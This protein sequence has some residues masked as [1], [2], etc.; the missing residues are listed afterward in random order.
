MNHQ[1][2]CLIYAPYLVCIKTRR[3]RPVTWREFLELCLKGHWMISLTGILKKEKLFMTILVSMG[4][5]WNQ[6]HFAMVPSPTTSMKIFGEG[7]NLHYDSLSCI[8]EA[9]H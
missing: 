8:L 5:H 1:M 3:D 4:G 6:I 9:A 7:K 2:A